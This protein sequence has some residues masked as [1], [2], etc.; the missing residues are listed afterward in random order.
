MMF[1]RRSRP[2]PHCGGVL[3]LHSVGAGSFWRQVWLCTT[4]SYGDN[5]Y[6]VVS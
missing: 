5:E 4:C 3:V 2:C 6:R 1:S